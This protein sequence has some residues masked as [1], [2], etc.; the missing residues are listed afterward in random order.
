MY[1]VVELII[2]DDELH[3]LLVLTTYLLSRLHLPPYNLH[4][5]PS[6]A[7][8]IPTYI[9]GVDFLSKSLA[10]YTNYSK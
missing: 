1:Q 5:Q 3:N 8:Q 4:A 2:A 9:N 10:N 7:S 6:S